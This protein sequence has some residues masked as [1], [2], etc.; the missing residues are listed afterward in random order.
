[1]QVAPD[2]SV[3]LLDESYAADNTQI[4]KIQDL[5]VDYFKTRTSDVSKG[6]W[7][8]LRHVSFDSCQI[9]LATIFYA[10]ISLL[11]LH[12]AQQG[13]GG[14]NSCLLGTHAHCISLGI[15]VEQYPWVT[16]RCTHPCTDSVDDSTCN[17]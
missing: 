7:N 3:R 12:P 5:M 14:S 16:I 1:M 11:V 13:I 2:F 10:A 8:A 17:I 6:G 15:F 9:L 4:S